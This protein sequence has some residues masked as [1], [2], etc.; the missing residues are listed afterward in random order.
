MKTIKQLTLCAAFGL[1]VFALAP[2]SHAQSS[3]VFIESPTSLTETLDGTP[4]GNWIYQGFGIWSIGGGPG[5][6]CP[7]GANSADNVQLVFADPLN[8]GLYDAVTGNVFAEGYSAIGVLT[9]IGGG[10]LEP[11]S[12]P[13]PA[14]ATS[15]VLFTQYG[16]QVVNFSGTPENVNVTVEAVPEPSTLALAGLGGLSLFFLRRRK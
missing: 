3:L 4:I 12:L 6:I 16:S 5:S 14:E 15:T 7:A 8:L 11:T 9:A 10:G 13:N 2:F 1:C